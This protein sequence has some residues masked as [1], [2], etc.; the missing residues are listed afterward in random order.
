[1]YLQPTS[2]LIRIT[3]VLTLQH[4][5]D[6]QQFYSEVSHTLVIDLALSCMARYSNATKSIHSAKHDHNNSSNCIGDHNGMHSN[7]AAAT[8]AAATVSSLSNL[9]ELTWSSS[10]L[11]NIEH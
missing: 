11:Q 6:Y 1:M 8:P 5:R 2:T 10:T 3:F 9:S 7:G 4:N